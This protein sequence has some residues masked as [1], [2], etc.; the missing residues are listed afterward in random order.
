VALSEEERTWVQQHPEV[1]WAADPEW[2]PFSSLDGQGNLSGIDVEIVHLIASRTGLQTKLVKTRNWSETLRKAS[3][4]EIDFVGGIARTDERERLLGLHFTEVFC[5]FPTAIVTRKD[6]PFLTSMRDFKSRRIALPRDYAT[7][8]ELQRL[9]PDVRLQL[10]ENEEQSML[11]VAGNAADA[12]AVNL[13]SASYIVHMRGLSNLKI[14]GFTEA[15]FFLSLAVK[16]DATVLRSI[17]AKGLASIG[18]M[19]KEAIYARYITPETRSALDWKTWRRR[20]IYSVMAGATALLGA[21]LWNRV[22]S[23]EI[24]RRKTA[25][26]ALRQA[27]VRLEERAKDLGSHARELETLNGKLKLAYQDLESFSYSVSHDLKAPLRRLRSFAD[28]LGMCAGEQLDSDAQKSIE[29]IQTETHRMGELI[30]SLLA[31]ARVDRAELHPVRVNLNELTREAINDLELETRGREL[32][33]ETSPLPD[34]QCDRSLIKAVF[35][36]LLGNATKFTRGRKPA[37]VKI[38]VSPEKSNNHEMVFFVKDNGAGFD[39]NQASSLFETF[40][41]LH[42]YEEFEG[43][44]IGLATVKRIIQKHGGR[45]WAEGVVNQGATFYFSLIGDLTAAAH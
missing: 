39:Q 23:R 30:E 45:V 12:T 36:N 19:E 9:Y 11:A 31:L 29:A 28:L 32:N 1:D 25:E 41:R 22:L 4:G 3:A 14:S 24:A 6:M 44:G 37:V 34:V 27:S 35:L 26:S 15:D 16:P 18:S 20:V 33:W 40:R 5:E 10:T 42:R 7:T 43:S 8:E 21:L 17:L 2:P 13:A 38:G